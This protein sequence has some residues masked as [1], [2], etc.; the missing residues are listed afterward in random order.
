MAFEEERQGV[1]E[2]GRRLVASGLIARTWGNVSCRI[3]DHTF[4]ITPSGRAYETLEAAEIVLINL[5]DLSYQGSIK[6]SSETRIHGAVYRL[7]KEINFVIHTHQPSASVISAV[8]SVQDCVLSLDSDQDGQP[9]EEIA[10]ADYGL[11]GSK[12]LADAVERVLTTSKAKA[13]LMRHHGALCFGRNAEEAFEVATSLEMI[14]EKWIQGRSPAGKAAALEAMGFQTPALPYFKIQTSERQ[15]ATI[16]FNGGASE[17]PAAGLE[18][19]IHKAIY[20]SRKDIHYILS[21]DSPEIL[22]ASTRG[23]ALKPLLDDMAQ[24]V[25]T[26]LRIAGWDSGDA[27][28]TIKGIL[29]ALKGRHGVL[30]SGCGALCC[31]ATKKDAEAVS[32][33]MEK[34]CRAANISD[35]TGPVK[36]INP[37]ECYLMRVNYLKNY[38]QK[39]KAREIKIGTV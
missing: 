18:R 35:L 7:K 16:L 37:L 32:L 13:I 4:A 27:A 31:G 25:G 26:S 34:G 6:P 21:A 8:A 23:K 10:F 5:R 22:K 1:V 38:S 28:G 39:S 15:S 17:D 12:K 3:D 20:G 11:P 2:A 24:I 14:C 9:G 36:G 30:I 33:I 29:A 19:Q